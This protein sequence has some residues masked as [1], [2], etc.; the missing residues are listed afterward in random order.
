MPDTDIFY[1]N[2]VTIERLLNLLKNE[3]IEI[4]KT[5]FLEKPHR[6]RN[7]E[8]EFLENNIYSVKPRKYIKESQN[9]HM[10]IAKNQYTEIENVAKEIN[11]L[12]KNNNLRYR[13]I[14]I[15]TKNVSNY[16]N[17]T[18]AIFSKYDIPV[19][20]DEKRELSQN[21]IVQ[22]VLSIFEIL[23]KNFA[24]LQENQFLII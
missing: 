24:T 13:D 20:I 15:I 10:F 5:I 23:Q 8:L 4:E 2:K 7:E 17:L 18:R 21:I 11:K 16:G 14:A 3:N 9:I 6:F 12:V 22:Y 1:P 19:F